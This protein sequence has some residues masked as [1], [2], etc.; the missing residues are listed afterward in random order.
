MPGFSPALTAYLQRLDKEDPLLVFLDITAGSETL[1]L[2]ANNEDLTWQGNLYTAF[3]FQVD[4]PGA[5]GKGAVTTLPLKICNVERVLRPYLEAYDGGV[6][7]PVTITLVNPAMLDEDYSEL[8]ATLFNLATDSDAS[9]VYFT[10]GPINPLNK[11]FPPDQYI[12][13]HCRFDFKTD[14]RCGY[15]GTATECDRSIDACRAL[16]NSRRFGG[17]MGLDG[18]SLRIV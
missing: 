6:G 10:L 16:G 18:R 17:H 13:K 4:M 2:V 14:P 11:P 9:W 3:S 12:A 15:A 8:T 1:R 7:L 5:D